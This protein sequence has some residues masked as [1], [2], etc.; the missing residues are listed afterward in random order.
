MRKKSRG[1][2]RDEE[3][4]LHCSFGGHP[5]PKARSF[6]TDK[7]NRSVMAS[8]ILPDGVQHFRRMWVSVVLLYPIL[9]GGLEE[10]EL[11]DAVEEKI[12]LWMEKEHP[13]VLSC[14]G[15]GHLR[16]KNGPKG[17]Q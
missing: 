6:L 5:S 15:M 16:T 7:D 14:D 2:F 9:F 13:F 1:V 17:N 3:Y 8:F 11:L 12:A 4:W 10:K